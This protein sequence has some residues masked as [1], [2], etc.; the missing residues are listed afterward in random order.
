MK[1]IPVFYDSRMTAPAASFS[2]S[3]SKPA[4]VVDDWQRHNL[5]IEIM[6]VYP[7]DREQLAMA[8]DA[9]HVED[10]LELRKDD[11]FGGRSLAVA[12]S[13]PW[14]TGSMLSAAVWLL[15]HPDRPVACSPTSGF[16]HAGYESAH[17]FCT[18]NGLVVT[19]IAL[20]RAGLAK[21][22]GILDFDHHEGDGTQDIISR[23]GL[24][25]IEHFTAGR[26]FNEADDAGAL[27][28]ETT[29]QAKGMADCDIVLYQAGA[30]MHIAD[31]LGGVLTTEQMR[32]RDRNVFW[33]AREYRIPL[34]WNLAGGYQRDPAGTIA[35]VLQL[36]RQTMQACIDIYINDEERR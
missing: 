26:Y 23:L 11:G 34:V 28:L 22:V 24:Q 29:R 3:A 16:H 13:L 21:R 4:A 18:F 12:Q 25:F 14:T 1:K 2:P 30:D 32:Q 36:H 27:L 6:P 10:I 35:P 5:P 19:A 8:H 15:S 9:Q 7:A 20:H 33:V 17:G 31:P